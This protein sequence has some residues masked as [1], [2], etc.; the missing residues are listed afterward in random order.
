MALPCTHE[1]A[2]WAIISAL[3]LLRRDSVHLLQV[4]RDISGKDWLVYV[5]IA[6][7]PQ[8][9]Y[10]NVGQN[11]L[12]VYQRRGDQALELRGS[13]REDYNDMTANFGSLHHTLEALPIPAGRVQKFLDP[14]KLY[15]VQLEQHAGNQQVSCSFKS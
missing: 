10:V 1:H 13:Y 11:D 6:P 8:T 14:Y 5:D 12:R 15:L 9:V 4:R 7:S 2:F 3:Q